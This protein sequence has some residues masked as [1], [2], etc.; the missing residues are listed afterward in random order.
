MMN[1]ASLEERET[2]RWT[3]QFKEQAT[4]WQFDPMGVQILNTKI[5]SLF[6][7]FKKGAL[8][9]HVSKYRAHISLLTED[10]F[11]FKLVQNDEGKGLQ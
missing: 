1:A 8:Y 4:F 5:L 9:L 3:L 7:T 10:Q 2:V 11:E 6:S